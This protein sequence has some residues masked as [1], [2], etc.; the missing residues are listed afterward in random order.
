MTPELL[1]DFSLMISSFAALVGGNVKA[2]LVLQSTD[3]TNNAKLS[4][5]VIFD[6]QCTLDPRDFGEFTAESLTKEMQFNKIFDKLEKEN[7]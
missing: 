5:S 7:N 6:H 1:S 3:P 4:S 2:T